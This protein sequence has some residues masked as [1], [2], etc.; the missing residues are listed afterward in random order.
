MLPETQTKA[1]YTLTVLTKACQNKFKTRHEAASANEGD[2][3]LI[4]RAAVS[5]LWNARCAPAHLHNAS[6]G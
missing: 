6:A 2:W 5:Q 4:K 1:E 3:W